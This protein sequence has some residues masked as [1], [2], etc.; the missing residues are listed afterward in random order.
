MR[1]YLVSALA[2]AAVGCSEGGYQQEGSEGAYDVEESPA[3]ST[4]MAP[5]SDAMGREAAASGPD[6]GP[7]A[8][9][10]VAFNY[11][12]AYRLPSERIATV[13]EAH[14]AACEELGVNRCRI[15]GM[16]YRVINETD[17]S[18]MLAFKLDPAIARGFGRE[19][20]ATVTE[21]EGMLVDAEISGTDVGA[22]IAV[23][24]RESARI[25]ED[26]AR[27]EAR[28]RA[29]G[30]S[31]DE[32]ARLDSEL[33]A[34]RQSLRALQDRRDDDQ[35]SL[36]TTPMVFNYGSGDVIP[37]FDGRTPIRN[38][39]S[40]AGSSFMGGVAFFIILIGALLPFIV[41]G[42]IAWGLWKAAR[43]RWRRRETPVETPKVGDAGD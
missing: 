27:I 3:P 1:A 7:T 24:D 34:L 4:P 10:G 9:P 14:A 28:L 13:Q 22:T 23:A 37:G 36:A 19:A 41:V 35:E 21:A 16:R 38:A 5:P 2:L 26:I 8:A 20:G 32:R 39:L 40:D 33:L 17:I 15:T 43:P 31:P 12:Y 18:A 29:P 30:I 6:I 25:Q 11:R 42:L